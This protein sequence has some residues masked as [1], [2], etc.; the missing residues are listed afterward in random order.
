MEPLSAAAA[1]VTIAAGVASMFGGDDGPSGPRTP[2]LPVELEAG[3]LDAFK[4]FLDQAEIEIKQS[5]D[6]IPYLESRLTLMDQVAQAQ[7][8]D[9]AILK[10][11]TDLDLQIA[12]RFGKETAAD[13]QAGIITDAAKKQTQQVQQLLQAELEAQGKN[14]DDKLSFELQQLVRDRL[15]GVGGGQAAIEQVR[16]ALLDEVKRSGDPI[17][18]RDPR[19]ERQLAS[20]EQ[21]LR[22]QLR[23]TLGPDYENTTMGRRALRDFMQGATET[24]FAVSQQM[25][26]DASQ[27]AT[28]RVQ[29]LSTLGQSVAQ[30][31]TADDQSLLAK[32]AIAKEAQGIALGR[33]ERLSALG[34]TIEG[35]LKNVILAGE[36]ER[37]RQEMDIK[38]AQVAQQSILGTRNAA[39]EGLMAQAEILKLRQIPMALRQRVTEAAYGR[40]QGYSKLAEQQFTGET[41]NA[42]RDGS[43]PG[44]SSRSS[45]YGGYFGKK[46]A[47]NKALADQ[48]RKTALAGAPEYR[49]LT[50]EQIAQGYYINP[51]TGSIHK[52]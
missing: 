35:Q 50:A 42:M 9:S 39:R 6:L 2:E 37:L 24:R 28:E 4:Q 51:S 34:T 43:V 12:Q 49:G 10:Q 33:I 21:A 22:A 44:V 25:K 7:T 15:A 52:L 23:Q 1:G 20:Q 13:V 5:K 47:E 32:T 46:E 48:R 36:P 11:L 26:K 38:R 18:E 27:L 45:I 40:S 17:P 41:K 8:P 14:V 19:V 3:Q 16:Q 30:N 31:V 29:R